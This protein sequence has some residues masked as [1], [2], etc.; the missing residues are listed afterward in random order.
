[1]RISDWSSDV[2][3]SDL[4]C[5][6]PHPELVL[7]GV[8]GGERDDTQFA[9]SYPAEPRDRHVGWD[10]KPSPQETV[11]NGQRKGVA[12]AEQGRWPRLHCEYHFDKAFEVGNRGARGVVSLKAVGVEGGAMKRRARAVET[13]LKLMHE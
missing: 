9:G 11:N 5:R 2:C 4:Q 8:D 13:A 7:R 6:S 1:M 10:V 3:S 12:G